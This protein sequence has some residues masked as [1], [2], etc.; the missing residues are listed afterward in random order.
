MGKEFLLCQGVSVNGAE[1][2]KSCYC[3]EN[4]GIS[5]LLS[6]DIIMDMAK[7]FI[8][9]IDEPVFFFLELPKNEEDGEGYD[10]Y[11]LDNCTKEVALAIVKRYGELLANDG[12][13][14]FGFGS[15]K[16]DEEIYFRDYQEFM[17]YSQNLKKLSKLMQE[18]EIEETDKAMSMWDLFTSENPGCCSAVELNGETVFDIPDN[19]KS[20]GMYKAD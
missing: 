18:L 13:S 12:L 17:I 14:R 19:L 10:V 4:D 8:K 6:Y 9:L 11:Y 7:E 1:N 15:H 2:M 5:G 16:T 20:A 3:V